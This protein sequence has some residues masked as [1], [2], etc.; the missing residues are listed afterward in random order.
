ME[1]TEFY[2]VIII[3]RKK[4]YFNDYILIRN[5]TSHSI[6]YIVYVLFSKVIQK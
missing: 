6:S 2:P 4:H 5:S 1:N 3:D